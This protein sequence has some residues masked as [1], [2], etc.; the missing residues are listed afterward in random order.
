[1][2]KSNPVR[3]IAENNPVKIPQKNASDVEIAPL[4]LLIFLFR[5]RE[6]AAAAGSIRQQPKFFISGMIIK[7]AAVKPQTRA[8]KYF[9]DVISSQSLIGI[10]SNTSEIQINRIEPKNKPV[11]IE[12]ILL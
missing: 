9:E 3:N 6:K 11:H 8:G 5:N 7:T 12:I 1:M 4:T 2:S 10:F